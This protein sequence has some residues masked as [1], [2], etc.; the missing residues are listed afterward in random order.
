MSLFN[1]LLCSIYLILENV[2]IKLTTNTNQIL[3]KYQKPSSYSNLYVKRK[4]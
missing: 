3:K 4:I 1:F 2:G